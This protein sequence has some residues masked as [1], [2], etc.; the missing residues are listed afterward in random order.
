M[1]EKPG[2]TEEKWELGRGPV[3]LIGR[4]PVCQGFVDVINRSAERVRVRMISLAGVDL[5]SIP[6]PVAARVF[7]RLD[8]H[9]R[10]RIPVQIRLHPAVSPGT[11]SGQLLCGSQ[12]EPVVIHVLES[13]RLEVN[14]RFLSITGRPKE[15]VNL[16]VFV[17]N[18]G[19][20]NCTLRD[21]DLI[22][23]EEKNDFCRSWTA[24]VKDSGK[25]GYEKFLDRFVSEMAAIGVN[26][27][28]VKIKSDPPE[29]HPG[30]VREVKV[31][32]R[33]P[34]NLKNNRVYSG[35]LVFKNVPL[36][37]EVECN[38]AART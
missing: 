2:M 12:K 30:E 14:P 31:E 15:K 26:P 1:N 25:A 18:Q 35:T 9:E 19:N 20:V 6:A 34:D 27:A 3:V 22:Y 5:K 21:V 13:E 7:A 16:R 4:P 10:S 32:L 17:T 37:L 8:P 11:Y 24:A 33:L 36:R 38:G 28:A 29:I 23:L